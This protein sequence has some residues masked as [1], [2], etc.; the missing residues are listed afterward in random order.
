[1]KIT[2][3]E[4]SADFVTLDTEKLYS[5]LKSHELSRKGRL[6][7]EITLM[8]RKFCVLHGFHKERRRSPR[9]CFECGDITHF[10]AD[11]PKR[12]KFDSSNKY[13]YNNRNNSSDKDEGKKKYLFGDK[14]KKKFQKMMSRACVAPS[15][16][17]F[18]NDDS[19]SSDENERPKR[20]MGDFTGL[21]LMGKSSRHIS[22]SDSDVSDDSSLDG[23]SLRV[24]ELENALCN[25]DKLLGK[26]FR[27]NKKLN[28]ELES[29]FSEIASLRS[30][31][32]D[33]S[34][35][36]CDR[37]TMIMVNYADMW[38]IHSHV[39]GLLDGARLEL[40][41]LKV[42]SIL[43][44]VCTSCPMLRSDLEAAAVEIKDL[45]HKI[46]HSSR[47]TVLSP[48][49]EACVSLKGKLLHATKENTELQQEVPI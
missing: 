36:P 32:E 47:Y 31:H 4:E 11:C 26:V 43:F 27:E 16:L 10:I 44:D 33:M 17:D 37:C 1:M 35:K 42:R 13:N 8:A 20:K 15:D 22:N 38:L 3:L 41:E 19:Y 23:I 30:A 14:K 39:A 45:K 6:N 40:R 46:D 34:A 28:L 18:S 48:P 21:C 5:K 9:G 49:C 2:V 24:V 25:Q 29:S 7:H 12:K